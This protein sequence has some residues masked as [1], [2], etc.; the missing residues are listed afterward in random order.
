[1]LVPILLL[2]E[3]LNVSSVRSPGACGGGEM[4]GEESPCLQFF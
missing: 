1:M 4:D 2:S 3:E